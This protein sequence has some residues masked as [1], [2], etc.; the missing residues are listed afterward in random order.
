MLAP[1]GGNFAVRTLANTVFLGVLVLVL[2]AVVQCLRGKEADIPAL[3]E[4]VRMQ[5]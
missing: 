3:S 1:L 4:A 5:L 2:Y